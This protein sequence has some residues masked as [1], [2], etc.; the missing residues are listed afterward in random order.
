MA[1]IHFVHVLVAT[2]QLFCDSLM[3]TRNLISDTL[4]SAIWPIQREHEK[5]AVSEHCNAPHPSHFTFFCDIR[6]QKKNFVSSFCSIKRTLRSFHFVTCVKGQVQCSF[7]LSLWL[8]LSIKYYI[9]RYG[10]ISLLRSRDTRLT[11]HKSDL[12]FVTDFPWLLSHWLKNL[13]T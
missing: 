10:R 3:S 4:L 9:P 5:G 2:T 11:L 8:E 1:A 6:K 7:P 13:T 12:K